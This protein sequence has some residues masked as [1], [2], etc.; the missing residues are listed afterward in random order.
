MPAS[1][2]KIEA[3]TDSEPL[4]AARFRSRGIIQFLAQGGV[5]NFT[6]F[7]Y[8]LQAS[9][10]H[11][12]SSSIV[13]DTDSDRTD[14]LADRRVMS[15]SDFLTHATAAG[16]RSSEV[17]SELHAPLLLPLFERIDVEGSRTVTWTTV[18][19]ACSRGGESFLMHVPR[20]KRFDSTDQEGCVLKRVGR[21]LADAT[22]STPVIM[23][24]GSRKFLM[25][26]VTFDAIT[27]QNLLFRDAKSCGA[28]LPPSRIGGTLVDTCARRSNHTN[29][30]R[31]LFAQALGF[32]HE[33]VANSA[34]RL[35][36][37]TP[38]RHALPLRLLHLPTVQPSTVDASVQ[39]FHE[40]LSSTARMLEDNPAARI[41]IPPSAL[42]SL[43]PGAAPRRSVLDVPAVQLRL[44][45]EL[46]TCMRKQFPDMAWPDVQP[47]P[48]GGEGQY[49]DGRKA[50]S[51]RGASDADIIASAMG[52]ASVSLAGVPSLLCPH[53]VFE[54]EGLR[55]V[56][57]HVRF[58]TRLIPRLLEVKVQPPVGFG[59]CSADVDGF[60]VNL[61]CCP[62][63]LCVRM[64]GAMEPLNIASFP[65]RDF[66]GPFSSALRASV[67]TASQYRKTQGPEHV[68]LAASTSQLCSFECRSDALA[69]VRVV[70]QQAFDLGME[71][72]GHLVDVRSDG[73]VPTTK[74]K[75]TLNPQF[76]RN[77]AHPQLL[78]P[79]TTGK[80]T[81]P[82]TVVSVGAPAAAVRAAVKDVLTAYC[83]LN[84]AGSTGTHRV[85]G[86][87]GRA[88]TDSVTVGG[89]GLFPLSVLVLLLY[90]HA[91][92][93][94]TSRPFAFVKM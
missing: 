52:M 56:E 41:V 49:D 32:T 92:D 43:P 62:Q 77:A 48:L 34:T 29:D 67:E 74:L 66:S 87:Y 42:L 7:C 16:C 76:I 33:I 35:R 19:A 47:R 46:S 22:R 79:T 3:G 17:M 82:V 64:Q 21:L 25:V 81:E 68:A 86:L 84:G 75:P 1:K 78:L 11:R 37:G 20:G 55:Q 72:S 61:S 90:R 26:N 44:L 9:V 39:T 58:H 94:E 83:A 71:L 30:V 89:G 91:Q 31:V 4:D 18:L 93:R 14:V 8:A 12:R 59:E 24:A 36:L 65:V 2:A 88:S 51:V 27:V 28:P 40:W 5:I 63:T 38:A 13:Y 45:K 85:E 15:A 60:A 10:V 23:N 69:A 70:Y 53:Q 50:R 6:T 54:P 57:Q 80:V 73:C